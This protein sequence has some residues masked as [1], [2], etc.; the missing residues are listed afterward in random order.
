MLRRHSGCQPHI[1]EGAIY[2]VSKSYQSTVQYGARRPVQANI[3]DSDGGKSERGAIEEVAQLVREKSQPFINRV[4]LLIGDDRIA[5][6]IEFRDSNGDSVVE[7]AVE[8]A[9][10]VCLKGRIAFES[11]VGYCLAEI[12]IVVNHLLNREPAL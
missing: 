10:L 4:R 6:A 5:L 7:A 8:S 3:T 2:E 9:E 12:A 1:G 11:E